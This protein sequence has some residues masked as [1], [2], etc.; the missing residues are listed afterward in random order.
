MCDLYFSEW[1]ENPEYHENVIVR[2]INNGKIKEKFQGYL[3]RMPNGV[4]WRT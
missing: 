4:F 3:C 1:Y 2:D